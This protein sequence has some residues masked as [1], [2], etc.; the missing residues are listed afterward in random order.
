MFEV[1]Y[2][3]SINF[4]SHKRGPELWDTFKKFSTQRNVKKH[5]NNNTTCLDSMKIKLVSEKDVT[6]ANQ[7]YRVF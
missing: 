4:P 1:G 7:K 5:H 2:I 6:S 3:D